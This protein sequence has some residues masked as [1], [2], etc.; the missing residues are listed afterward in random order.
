VSRRTALRAAK[1]LHEIMQEERVIGLLWSIDDVQSLRPDLTADQ[2]WS[3]L[4]RVDDQKDATLGITWDTLDW[5]ADDLF[6][7]KDGANAR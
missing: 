1:T 5:A 2:A 4:Q 7:L 6:P 3:V